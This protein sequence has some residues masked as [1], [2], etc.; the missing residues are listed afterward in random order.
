MHLSLY[1][2]DWYSGRTFR[3]ANSETTCQTCKANC[4]LQYQRILR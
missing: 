2:E 3:G 4:D 1:R